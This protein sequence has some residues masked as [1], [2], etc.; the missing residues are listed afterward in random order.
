MWTL[1]GSILLGIGAVFLICGVLSYAGIMKTD[2]NSR[3]DP[4]VVFPMIGAVLIAAGIVCC[5][6]GSVKEK[7]RESLLKN[8]TSVIGKVV[9]VIQ[10]STTNWGASHPYV[11]Y[12]S[13]ENAGI[14]YNG[15]SC[16]LWEKPVANG[17]DDIAV[18]MDE[19]NPKHSAVD[20]F[21]PSGF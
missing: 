14:Q 7:R 4:K 11:V 17:G 3:G 12:Y 8:G 6:I 1:A 20:F 2:L 16:L 19:C 18:F 9:S 10:Y 13:Y 15:R 5:I 21:H